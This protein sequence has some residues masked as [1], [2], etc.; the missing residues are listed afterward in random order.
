MIQAFEGLNQM[1][2]KKNYPGLNLDDVSTKVLFVR[3]PYG[4]LFSAYVDKL[5]PPNPVFWKAWGQRATLE[6]RPHS[7]ENGFVC[8]NDTTF[9]EFISFATKRAYTYDV[10]LVPVYKVCAP[11]KVKYNTIGKMESFERDAKYAITRAGI[12]EKQIRFDKMKQDQEEDALSDSTGGSFS[13][14]W[15]QATL[16]CITLEA[17]AQRVWRK[18]QIRGFISW[19]QRLQL[20]AEE[21]ANVDMSLMIGLLQ[22]AKSRSTNHTE[23]KIQKQQAFLEAYRTL[24]PHQL[25]QI[26]VVYGADFKLFDYDIR[27]VDGMLQKQQHIP[28]TGAL[29]WTKDWDLSPVLQILDT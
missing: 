24:E 19:R 18:L 5:V 20:T 13:P 23:L 22:K 1:N 9:S 16:R 27:L 7:S 4:R 10:H 15:L 12:S 2:V 3:E 21:K 14:Q 28:N 17:A 29:D 11:C 6:F 26:M 8:G 25:L